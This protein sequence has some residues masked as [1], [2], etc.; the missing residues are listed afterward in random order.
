MQVDEDPALTSSAE[1][2][3]AI[4]GEAIANS[5]DWMRCALSRE[6]DLVLLLKLSYRGHGTYVDAEEA[7]VIASVSGLVERVNK[8]VSV[9]A[10]RS[11]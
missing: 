5:Q 11:K 8:L 10:L 9:R 2:R 6:L 4:P 3:V 7:A 1:A